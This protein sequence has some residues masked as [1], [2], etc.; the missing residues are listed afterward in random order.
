MRRLPAK[1]AL[2]ATLLLP[3]AALA[4]T[5]V[6]QFLFQWTQTLVEMDPG[7]Y[8]CDREGFGWAGSTFTP[9]GFRIGAGEDGF[10]LTCA[11]DESGTWA[12]RP[13]DLGNPLVFHN[14]FQP[15]LL[16]SPISFNLWVNNPACLSIR[17]VL[18][19]EIIPGGCQELAAGVNTLTNLAS[20]QDSF[21]WFSLTPLNTQC[22][23]ICNMFA[24][25]GGATAFGEEDPFSWALLDIAVEYEVPGTGG[26]GDVVPEPTTMSLL[27][28][29]LALL[30]ARRRRG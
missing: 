27:A 22:P 1:V 19:G 9:S 25:K 16:F 14:E 21:F 5:T 7:T 13:L 17:G 2:A 11:S 12:V 15:D 6:D 26:P 23:T 30:A 18:G 10:G 20:V 8:G 24:A 3:P 28:T 29:G 4:Q